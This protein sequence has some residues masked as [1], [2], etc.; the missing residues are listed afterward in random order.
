MLFLR[1]LAPVRHKKKFLWLIIKI[2]LSYRSPLSLSKLP[3]LISLIWVIIICTDPDSS[4]CKLK[5][6]DKL[7][8]T[9]YL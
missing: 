7:L 8:L 6:I 2:Y 1:F 3:V 9:C 5:N 4:H